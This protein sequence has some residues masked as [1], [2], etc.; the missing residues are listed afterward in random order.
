[1][2]FEGGVYASMWNQQQTEFDN[3]DE[4]EEKEDTKKK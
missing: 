4:E 3:R 2:S 1:M